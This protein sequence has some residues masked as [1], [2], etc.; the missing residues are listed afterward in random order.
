MKTKGPFVKVVLLNEVVKHPLFKS[1]FDIGRFF[2]SFKIFQY[3]HYS[4]STIFHHSHA[5]K[6]APHRQM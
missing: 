2:D 5:I 6:M 1:N 4:I 3:P